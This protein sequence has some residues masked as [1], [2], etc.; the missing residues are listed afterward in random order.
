MP[1]S[2]RATCTAPNHP[3]M[4]NTVT[5]SSLGTTTILFSSFM[6]VLTQPLP[7]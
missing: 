6:N 3:T 5:R 4:F 2:A 7:H 1:H